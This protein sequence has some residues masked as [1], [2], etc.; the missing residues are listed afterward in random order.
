MKKFTIF[1]MVNDFIPEEKSETI[2]DDALQ[3]S[4][5]IFLFHSCISIKLI[6]KRIWGIAGEEHFARDRLIMCEDDFT[7]ILNLY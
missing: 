1:F 6:S 5:T 2:T 3:A 7:N 4:K